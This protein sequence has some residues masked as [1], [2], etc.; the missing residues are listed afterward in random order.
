MYN[1]WRL[2]ACLCA[3]VVSLMHVCWCAGVCRRCSNTATEPPLMS[4]TLVAARTQRT[5]K[6]PDV[7]ILATIHRYV[8][9]KKKYEVED[10]HPEESED[11]EQSAKSVMYLLPRAS[12]IPLPTDH[13]HAELPKD[14]EVLAMFPKSTCFYRATVVAAQRK[15]LMREYLLKFDDDEQETGETPTRRVSAQHVVPYPSK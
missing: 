3:N 13:D 7:W 2:P 6:D 8:P 10:E 9:E 1:G 4:G 5:R 14:T 12:L 11:A 15:K